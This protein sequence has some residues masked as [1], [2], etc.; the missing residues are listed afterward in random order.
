MGKYSNNDLF[1]YQGSNINSCDYRY[2]MPFVL[3]LDPLAS[4]ELLTISLT[5]VSIDKRDN[6]S[7]SVAQFFFVES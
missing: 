1:Q 2:M 4:G 7:I 5:V 6:K 3:F